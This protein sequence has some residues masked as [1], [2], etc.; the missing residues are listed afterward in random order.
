MTQSYLQITPQLARQIR[1][2]M[3][4]VDGTLT[5]SSSLSPL[6]SESIC[7]LEECGIMV[8]LVSGRTLPGLEALA[9]DLGI[10]GPVIAE[11]GAVARVKADGEIVDLGYSCQPALRDLAKLKKLF[12]DAITER[13]D[14]KDRLVDVVFWSQGIDTDE[15]RKHLEGTQLLDS[16]YILHLV[17]EGVS[18]GKTLMTILARIGNGDLSPEEVLVFGDSLTDMSLFE[19]F[20][21]S[22][23]ITN[24]RLP[25]EQRQFLQGV[26][27][28]KSKLTSGAGFAEVISHILL[29]RTI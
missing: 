1:L 6:V 10:G 8:G 27:R 11:N 19:L 12:P 16:G 23:L 28:Y 17:Q 25:V 2:V 26:A 7:R 29:T 13:E 4:D 18:K 24:A 15:L 21:Y 20:P 5:H 3:A 14:N 9:R 22:V